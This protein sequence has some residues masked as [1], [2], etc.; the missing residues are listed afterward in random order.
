MVKGVSY[1]AFFPTGS[2]WTIYT[3][4]SPLGYRKRGWNPFIAGI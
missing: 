3:P 2:K 1:E 4:T